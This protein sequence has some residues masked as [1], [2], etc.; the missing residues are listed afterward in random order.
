MI[1]FC[2]PSLSWTEIYYEKC[3]FAKRSK[4]CRRLFYSKFQSHYYDIETRKKEKRKENLNAKLVPLL[5]LK[6]ALNLFFT[7]HFN[8]TFL[9][10]EK[11]S[12]HSI[13]KIYWNNVKV[14]PKYYE[15]YFENKRKYILEPNG[16]SCIQ[17]Q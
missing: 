13:Q 15:F 6:R 16:E 2:H 5:C 12:K 7:I 9:F 4:H 17:T 1:I 8:L 11:L 10:E 14:A 3:Y